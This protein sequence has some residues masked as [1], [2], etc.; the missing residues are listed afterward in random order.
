MQVFEIQYLSESFRLP[1]QLV[2]NCQIKDDVAFA[3]SVGQ[4]SD[5]VDS[6]V[7]CESEFLER[8]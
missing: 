1:I 5:L 7:F 8:F 2:V 4:L 3:L 6:S